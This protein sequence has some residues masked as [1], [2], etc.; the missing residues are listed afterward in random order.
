MGAAAN[1]VVSALYG[2]PVKIFRLVRLTNMQERFSLFS[3]SGLD[4][5]T[6][7]KDKRMK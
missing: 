1:T 4:Q 6:P 5:L 2:I 7:T 3:V